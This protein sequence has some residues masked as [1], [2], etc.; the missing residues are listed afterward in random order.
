MPGAS[1][2]HVG[3]TLRAKGIKM[4]KDKLF[5]SIPV[6]E[7]DTISLHSIE[8]KDAIQLFKIYNN[9]I[10]FQYCGILNKNNKETVRK[11]IPH[12]DRDF[13]KQHRIKWGIFEKTKDELLGIIEI[14][15]INQITN[16]LTI[17]YYSHP[18]YWNKGFTKRAVNLLIK[19]L[20]DHIGINR[21]A[22][23]VM[24]EN[25]NSKKVIFSTGFKKEGLIRQGH[26][27]PGKG[28][29]DLELYSQLK[30]DYDGT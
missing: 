23:Y 26:F 17:G 4:N 5:S 25:E 13:K 22:A 28:I 30:A 8:E 1:Y 3:W 2:P 19:Y 14:M 12:F 9:N 11:M 24:P 21:I 20:F 29:I 10:I 18:D 16:G 15:D 7:D 27:W 6:L